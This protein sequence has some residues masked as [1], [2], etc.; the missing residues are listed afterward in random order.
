METKRLIIILAAV[1]VCLCGVNFVMADDLD[2][3]ITKFTDEAISGDDELGGGSPNISH[4][5]MKAKADASR[6][7]K[8]DSKNNQDG[9]NAN[10]KVN[11]ND[12]S[13]DNNQNSV[14]CEVGAKCGTI[15][16]IIEN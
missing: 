13:G 2:D 11:V 12:G 4:V 7:K 14:V 6:K 15:I 9:G 16:N 3:N 10:K 8:Q 1:F 5:I